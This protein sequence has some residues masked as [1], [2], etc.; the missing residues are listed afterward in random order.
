M[1]K[2]RMLRA[3]GLAAALAIPLSGMSLLSAGTAGATPVHPGNDTITLT[4]GSTIVVTCAGVTSTQP[5]ATGTCTAAFGSGTPTTGGFTISGITEA[6]AATG[7]FA[8]N[9]ITA[10]T[11]LAGTCTITF[12]NRLSVTTHGTA[13]AETYQTGSFPVAGNTSYTGS[14]TIVRIFIGSSTAS[15]TLYSST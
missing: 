2:S 8:A 6:A 5:I 11:S 15:I 9:S 1:M 4:L 10:H 12:T 3:C 13:P 14:C 7:H